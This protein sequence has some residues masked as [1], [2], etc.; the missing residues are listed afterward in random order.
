VVSAAAQ[1]QGQQQQQQQQAATTQ[2]DL[3]VLELSDDQAEVM[4][5]ILDNGASYTFAVRG[6]DDHEPA[7]SKGITFDVLVTNYQ[8]PMPKSVHLPSETQ[9]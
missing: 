1:Q 3:L 6:K 2:A 8:L 5:F 4:K 9:P 7:N